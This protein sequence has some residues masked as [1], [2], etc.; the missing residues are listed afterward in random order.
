MHSA[1]RSLQSHRRL[2]SRHLPAVHGQHF[3][4]SYRLEFAL[5]A[6]R[7]ELVGVSPQ[8]VM[9]CQR[10]NSFTGHSLPIVYNALSTSEFFHVDNVDL[11]PTISACECKDVGRLPGLDLDFRFSMTSLESSMNAPLIFYLN[12]VC[13]SFHDAINISISLIEA[14]LW[15]L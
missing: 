4:H 7:L 3:L 11:L 14:C 12:L 10:P 13:T 8:F 9:H 1:E 15:L 5:H 6:Q 2:T